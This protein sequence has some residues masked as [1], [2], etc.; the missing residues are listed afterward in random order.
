MTFEEPL[1]T[2]T[3][4]RLFVMLQNKW[5]KMSSMQYGKGIVRI[6]DVTD[7]WESYIKDSGMTL[8]TLESS[9]LKFRKSLDAKD[10]NHYV[11]DPV[12]LNP[13][14]IVVP[15]ELAMKILTLGALPP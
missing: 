4:R 5:R 10:E 8:L 9:V 12:S 13:T 15:D 11:I 2:E 7:S 1:T 3:E 14:Y 6:K